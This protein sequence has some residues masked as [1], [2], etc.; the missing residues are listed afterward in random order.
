MPELLASGYPS[1]DMIMPVSRLPAAGETAILSRF[2]EP[3]G[4][5]YG[6][7]GVNVA[8]GLGRLGR[9]AGVAMTIGDDALGQRYTAYLRGAGVNTDAVRVL[10]QAFT[11]RSYLF[12]GP[13]GE[14]QNYF[15]PGAADLD[16][17]FPE[18][19][20][21]QL[22][23]QWSLITVG[24]LAYNQR[25]LECALATGSR[26]A[27]Q[28]KAD[29]AAYPQGALERFA[30]QSA[31]IFCNRLEAAYLERTLRLRS[32]GDLVGRGAQAVVL[33]LG[34]EGSLVF[35]ADG[36]HTIPAARC[37]LV[38]TTGAGDAYTAGFMAGL[39]SGWDLPACGRLGA[40]MAA[41]V[42]ES[43]GCQSNLPDWP[44]LLSRYQREFGAS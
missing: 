13:D 39:L 23:P 6:G 3:D 38:D 2:V 24:P 1:L 7:C 22:A 41:F 35:S 40:V 18:E 26:I 21:R 29:I 15:Y 44:S 42:L 17:T 36:A 16:T 8:V 25:M 12:R 32:V 9:Q 27:W 30:S 5:T 4:Y 14:Y 11:S 34:A 33:T 19:A 31:L 37:T 28:L 43:I 10:P 20:F